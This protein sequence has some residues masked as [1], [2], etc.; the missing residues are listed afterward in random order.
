M[1]ELNDQNKI[2][3]N[4]AVEHENAHVGSPQSATA[5]NLGKRSA[6]PMLLIIASL[7]MAIIRF[8]LMLQ[9]GRLP[10]TLY[11]VIALLLATVGF[12]LRL[13]SKNDRWRK[14]IGYACFTFG[15]LLF[16]LFFLATDMPS[17][18]GL[19]TLIMVV[20]LLACG[21]VFSL[22]QKNSPLCFLGALMVMVGLG[23]ILAIFGNSAGVQLPV[24]F[25]IRL[26]V[27]Y[28]GGWI[29]F[30]TGNNPTPK[31]IL[32]NTLIV[33]GITFISFLILMGFIH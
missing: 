27:L 13:K 6:W 24:I 23:H 3:S 30:F 10:S 15:F 14:T 19:L 28:W 26:N 21:I 22:A 7:A 31:S 5:A 20:L 33:F 25:F 16:S 8:P 17:T 4:K 29:L 12:G 18:I 1:G 9:L 11:K 32:T 2:E